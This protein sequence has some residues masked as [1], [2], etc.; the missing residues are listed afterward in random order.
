[1]IDGMWPKFHST[2]SI[3]FYDTADI[4]ILMQIQFQVYCIKSA[5]S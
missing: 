1:M 4:G 2:I 5:Q 3:V